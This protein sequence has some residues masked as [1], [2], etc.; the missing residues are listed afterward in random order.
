MS[1]SAWVARAC[2]AAGLLCSLS[3]IFVSP[4]DAAPVCRKGYYLTSG[5]D[6]APY[7]GTG[8][9]SNWPN[10][11]PWANWGRE[12]W[13][14][15]NWGPWPNW[16][17]PYGRSDNGWTGWEITGEL[18]VAIGGGNWDTTSVISLGAGD[19][20]VDGLKDLADTDLALALAIGYNYQ[21][22]QYLLWGVEIDID[23]DFIAMDP[24]IPGTG[25]IGTAAVRS[26]DSVTVKMREGVA[27]LGRLGYLVTPSTL[28]YATGGPA[29]DE[30]RATVNCTAAGV[31]GTNG[32][33]PFSQTN[34]NF[35]LGYTVGAGLEQKLQGNWRGRIEYRYSAFDTFRT[36][37]G[38]PGNL[39]VAANID[40]H[41]SSVM[42]GLT[43][44]F[45]R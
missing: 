15:P 2:T 14:P 36:N 32:I 43:Y 42:F 21:V 16:G 8:S 6:C 10:W 27:L 25:A 28:L 44:A 13:G 9:R 17:T 39:A 37:F 22:S 1:V 33:P 18:G 23:Y 5:G 31:C 26:H 20:I 41:K 24:G 29:W 30:I 35:T 38:T 11:G 12:Y 7:D 4:A 3:A 34:S 19:P 40:V 45:G